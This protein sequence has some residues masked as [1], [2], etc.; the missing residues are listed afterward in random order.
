MDPPGITR[1]RRPFL[2]PLWLGM[3]AV[4]VLGATALSYYRS[5][6]TSLLFL[7]TAVEKEPGAI[8]DPPL[9]PEDEQRAQRL[10]QMFGDATGPGWL[11][12][13]Y[14]SDERRA[15]QTAAAVA[16]RLHRA[17]VV[18]AVAAA[19]ATARDILREHAGGKVLVIA[20]S[21][22][23]AELIHELQGVAVA[24]TTGESEVLYVLA[25]PSMGRGQ[26]ARIRL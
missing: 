14:V 17:P 21:A 15:Q 3:L 26:L 19:R 10:A 23:L 7:V 9:S 12:A 8:D 25:V 2:A 1:S 24:A 16:Q 11:D 6:S 18:F 22:T 20:S 4:L 13:L 5:A